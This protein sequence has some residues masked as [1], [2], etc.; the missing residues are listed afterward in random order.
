MGDEAII[1]QLKSIVPQNNPFTIS[2]SPSK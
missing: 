2:L 1:S